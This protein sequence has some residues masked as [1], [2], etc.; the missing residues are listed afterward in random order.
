[1]FCI[2]IY[3]FYA[4]SI[5]NVVLVGSRGGE[6]IIYIYI[7]VYMLYTD[8]MSYVNLCDV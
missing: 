7:Y 6:H 3:I 2:Y 5:E 4:N 8:E 1:M